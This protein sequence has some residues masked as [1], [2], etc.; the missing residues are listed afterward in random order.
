MARLS[1]DCSGLGPGRRYMLQ[2]IE[3][4]A[5]KPAET[6]MEQ[7]DILLTVAE[8][9]VALVGFTGIIG[10]LSR[11]ED[12]TLAEFRNLVVM[13]RAGFSATGLSLLPIALAQFF[14]TTLAWQLSIS[15][16]TVVMG[17]NLY[18]FFRNSNL[19]NVTISQKIMAP[20]AIVIAI[21]CALAAVGVIGDASRLYIVAIFWMLMV[22]S[23]NFVILLAG[24]LITKR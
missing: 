1:A 22:A 6:S 16:L 21:A 8:L 24:T 12:W 3:F 14:S 18:V 4:P 5:I 9:A 13:L 11:K 17:S 2:A 7:Q 19:K 23:H 10:S 20:I 15:V